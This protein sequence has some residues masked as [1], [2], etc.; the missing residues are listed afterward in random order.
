MTQHRRPLVL[1]ALCLCAFAVNLDVTL[2][3]V[4]LPRLSVDL[5]AGTRDLQWIVDAYTL[6]F[7]A[8]VLPAGSL[9][10]RFGRRGAL[11]TG[12]L[13]YGLGNG[14]GGL[15]DSTGALIATRALMGVGA[16]LIF[17]TTLSIITNVYT[18]RT[19][20]A[21]AIGIWG[22]VTGLAI[23][24]GPIAGPGVGS[25]IGAPGGAEAGTRR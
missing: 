7:A 5:G 17:P 23:A 13:V 22:A 6:T 8:L 24:L 19:E 21:K 16:A 20:R 9:G 12:L 11:V 1:A 18:E 3:N 2:V 4:T 25:H 14:L 10:D 15:V